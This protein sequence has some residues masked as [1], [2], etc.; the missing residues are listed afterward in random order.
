MKIKALMATCV[1]GLAAFTGCGS[2]SDSASTTSSDS[3]ASAPKSTATGDPIVVG[4]ICSC[5][6]AQSAVLGKNSEASKAW[7]ASVNAAGGI[8]GHPV[9]LIVKDD[10]GDPAKSLNAAKELIDAKVQAI[11]GTVSVTT[12]VWSKVIDKAGIPV[13]GGLPTESTFLT[14]ANFYPSGSSLP[15]VT[16]GQLSN[17]KSAGK[18]KFGALYCAESPICGSLVPILDR[19]SKLVGIGVYTA[20]VAA[21]AP[22]Y[23][24]PCLGLKNAGVDAATVV[25]NSTVA[26]RVVNGCA[27][28]NYKPQQ[29]VNVT[30]VGND[31]LKNPNFDG[32]KV[33]APNALFTD[34]AIPAV[35]AFQDAI[36][37]QVPDVIGTPLYNTQ[38]LFAW[39][40]GKLF[41]AAAAKAELTPTSTPEDVKKGLYALKDESLGG[42]SGPLTFTKG[43]PAF[44][45][46]YFEAEIKDNAFQASSSEPKCLDPQQVSAVSAA[47]TR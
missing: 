11:V 5:S 2:D 31:S 18:K 47:L 45:S 37:A 17:A 20:K 25:H 9:K 27:K 4:T 8:N 28:Q 14:D 26:E 12:A 16:Y 24:A 41:E 32:T 3:A 42:L 35:K 19:L 36:K 39:A 38:M 1:V 6:G 13:V 30:T 40:G 22:N 46:C 23:T 10:A 33:V 29:Y 21:T 7:A 43:K 44:P 34:D 15:V